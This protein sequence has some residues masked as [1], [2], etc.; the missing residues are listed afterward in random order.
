MITEKG[1]IKVSTPITERVSRELN[2]KTRVLGIVYTV[3]GAVVLA[4]AFVSMIL[5]DSDFDSLFIMLGGIIL[6]M[7]IFLLVACSNIIKSVRKYAKVDEVEFFR[8]YLIFREYTDGEHTS[9][10]KIYYKWLVKTAESEHYLFLYNTKAS[11]VCVEK[12]A[13]PVGELNTVRTILSRATGKTVYYPDSAP[14]PGTQ[15]SFSQFNPNAQ[16]KGFGQMGGG[17]AATNP[18]TEVKQAGPA[19][20]FDE[21]SAKEEPK[22]EESAEVPDEGKTLTDE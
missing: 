7:G 13:L 17:Y 21:F 14:M 16:T 15:S 11:A 5:W 10:A 18:E 1:S 12:S 3:V 9:T 22:A 19:D 8:D 2:K 4:A 6:A 20:P